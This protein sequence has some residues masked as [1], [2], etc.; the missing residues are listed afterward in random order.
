VKWD[1][2]IEELVKEKFVEINKIA[3]NKGKELAEKLF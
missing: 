2:V 1:E 3:F